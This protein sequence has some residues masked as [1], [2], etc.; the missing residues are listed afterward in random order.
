M[1]ACWAA[2]A[3]AC[4]VPVFQWALENWAPDPYGVL[5]FH[6]GPIDA[7]SRAVVNF[8]DQAARSDQAPA[9]VAARAVDVSKPMSPGIE[10][11]W[12]AQ[13]DP[14][15]PRMLVL[16]PMRYGMDPAFAVWSGSPSM[17]RAKAL[18][19][20]PARR[21]IANHIRSGD[22]AVWVLL[23]SGDR[24]ADDA[25]A[26]VLARELQRAEELLE[27][28]PQ[29]P[30]GLD[31]GIGY[32]DPAGPAPATHP[33]TDDP[34]PPLKPTFSMLRVSRADPAEATFVATLLA[35]E[36]GLADEKPVLPMAFPIFGQGRVVEPFIGK[37]IEPDNILMACEFFVGPCSCTIKAQNPGTDL[38]F[39]TDWAGPAVEPTEEAAATP[40]ARPA[41]T[42]GLLRNVGIAAGA[43]IVAALVAV[44]LVS[45]RTSRS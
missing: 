14:K 7:D 23:E 33:E 43:L 25:A 41:A 11:I 32:Q 31:Q 28:P 42:G 38:L 27:L 3:R 8:L 2:P 6:H 15:L 36:P 21:R 9:N 24:A 1:P 26:K 12:K 5:I 13:P 17:D 4:N 39:A 37:G 16:P 40:Q 34:E 22:A 45:R 18:I 20:S 44:V 30:Y 19:D 35:A 10:K 29:D